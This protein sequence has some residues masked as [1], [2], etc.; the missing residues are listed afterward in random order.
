MKKTILIAL[1]WTGLFFGVDYLLT[2]MHNDAVDDI[3]GRVAG[4][5]AGVIV[6]VGFAIA[7]MRKGR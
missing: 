4:M 3:F 6:V 5:G 7:L 2:G 1:A